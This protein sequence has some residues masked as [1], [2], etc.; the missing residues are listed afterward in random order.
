MKF[1]FV[2]FSLEDLKAALEETLRYMS[3]DPVYGG[4]V[5]D[6]PPNLAKSTKRKSGAQKSKKAPKKKKTTEKKGK[7][8]KVS[9]FKN[10]FVGYCLL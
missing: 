7:Q 6:Q 4:L 3:E 9:I 8:G 5:S 2:S 1:T 10:V